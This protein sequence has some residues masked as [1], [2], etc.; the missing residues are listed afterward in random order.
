ML[1]LQQ[2][3]VSTLSLFAG[4]DDYALT[5]GVT[6]AESEALLYSITHLE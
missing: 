1:S 5:L 4:E 3:R 6:V 2:A